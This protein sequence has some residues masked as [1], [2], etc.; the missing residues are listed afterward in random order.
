L[1]VKKDELPDAKAH[2]GEAG[3]LEKYF[4]PEPGTGD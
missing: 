3:K 1:T 4:S 2:D